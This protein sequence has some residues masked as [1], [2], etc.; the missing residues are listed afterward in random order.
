MKPMTLDELRRLT[1]WIKSKA[2]IKEAPNITYYPAKY[3]SCH[4]QVQTM[5]IHEITIFGWWKNKDPIDICT[6]DDVDDPCLL[7]Y[8]KRMMSELAEDAQ[9]APS[10]FSLFDN[11]EEENE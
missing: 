7:K 6:D 11:N 3:I 4:I 2:I 9:K 5:E 8:A 1:N 10:K